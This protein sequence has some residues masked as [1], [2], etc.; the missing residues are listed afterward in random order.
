MDKELQNYVMKEVHR[1]GFFHV[2]RVD[3]IWGGFE[4]VKD[5]EFHDAVKKLNDI[6]K[7]AEEFRIDPIVMFCD[8]CFKK[9]VKKTRRTKKYRKLRKECSE[10][11]NNL[12][13]II[14]FY[15]YEEMKEAIK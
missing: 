5:D 3:S 11:V 15:D 14:G 10:V 6:D 13:D 8:P 2:F 4:E 12:K 9:A 1:Y 7:R